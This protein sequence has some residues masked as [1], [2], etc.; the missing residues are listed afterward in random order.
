[1]ADLG[2]A[3]SVVP[4]TKPS[5]LKKARMWL[6]S[7]MS[8]RS[9][10]ARLRFPYV[11][12]LANRN[13]EVVTNKEGQRVVLGEGA[14]ATVYVVK[15][16]SSVHAG[17]NG[18]LFAAKVVDFSEESDEQELDNSELSHDIA[19]ILREAMFLRLL[20]PKC[21]FITHFVDAFV[22]RSTSVWLVSERCRPGNLGA[23]ILTEEV[24][25]NEL[26]AILYCVASALRVIHSFGVYHGDIKP[27]NLLIDRKAGVVKVCDFGLTDYEADRKKIKRPQ[28]T[29]N[30][31]APEVIEPWIQR[32]AAGIY[33]RKMDIWALGLLVL[34]FTD[35]FPWFEVRDENELWNRVRS[36]EA[37]EFKSIDKVE[38]SVADFASTCLVVNYRRRSNIAQVLQ[39]S[40][41]NREEVQARAQRSAIL[42]AL[43]ERCVY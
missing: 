9:R 6:S 33:T 27:S 41:L 5:A 35:Q 34:K 13:L 16:T 29:I 8:H 7:R 21:E 42:R 20:S 1:M 14:T 4:S 19:L 31:C 26:A 17:G 22:L 30:Y 43:C 39:H 40:L 38:L 37:M 28:G 24:S 18:D 23:L 25:T 3:S 32:G 12:T 11:N 15:S 36:G 2:E 10:S